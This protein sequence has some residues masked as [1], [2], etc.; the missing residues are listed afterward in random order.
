MVKKI[1]SWN[2]VWFNF[3]ES[4]AH[5]HKLCTHC[6]GFSIMS[7]TIWNCRFL[8]SNRVDSILPR[9]FWVNNANSWMHWIS[10]KEYIIQCTLISLEDG[11]SKPTSYK[12]SLIKLHWIL[13]FPSIM[14][15]LCI[16]TIQESTKHKFRNHYRLCL[17]IGLI[18]R[19]MDVIVFGS[20]VRA[21]R[22][23]SL[24][25][26][27]HLLVFSRGLQGSHSLGLMCVWSLMEHQLQ[28]QTKIK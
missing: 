2:S 8:I 10:R 19:L 24:L 28:R 11:K 20:D 23:S 14:F 1:T 9:Y 21:H 17:I 16:R 13:I 5:T 26:I 22:S 12:W 6:Y 15:K 7:W 4:E 27:S 25:M 18:A 3:P